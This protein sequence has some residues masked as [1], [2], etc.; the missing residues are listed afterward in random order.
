MNSPYSPRLYADRI[1]NFGWQSNTEYSIFVGDGLLHISSIRLEND[2]CALQAYRVLVLKHHCTDYAT[3]GY[4]LSGG[5]RQH[6]RP[7][8]TQHHDYDR[9]PRHC[10]SAWKL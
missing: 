10:D 5:G 7:P 9:I 3:D 2:L 1:G 6:S 4:P 8:D